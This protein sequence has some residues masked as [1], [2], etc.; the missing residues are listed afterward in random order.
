[1]KEWLKSPTL[2]IFLGEIILYLLLWL[3]KADIAL[4]LTIAFTL[5][6]AAI[7]VISKLAEFFSETTPVPKSYFYGV[8]VSILAPIVAAL[9]SFFVLGIPFFSN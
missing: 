6:F 5:I 7:W 8:V 1:M 3:W 9:I 4:M 2:E